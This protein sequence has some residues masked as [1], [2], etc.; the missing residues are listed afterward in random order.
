MDPYF[1]RYWF[2]V[3]DSEY[4]TPELAPVRQLQAHFQGRVANFLEQFF[5]LQRK[6][7]S[8]SD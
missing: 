7:P 3:D 1:N 4:E 5:Q 6:Q 2:D 8:E